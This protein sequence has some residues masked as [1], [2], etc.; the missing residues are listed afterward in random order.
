M[1]VAL[2]IIAADQVSKMYL[3]D[4]MAANPHGI[5][6]TSFFNLVMVWNHGVSFGMFAGGGTTRWIL[7]G[8]SGVISI[9]V[10]AMLK[11][12]T[13]KLLAVGLG[14]VLGGAIG[15]IF[16]RINYGAVA[17]FFDFD[18]IFMRWPAFNIADMA[19]VCGVGLMLLES[20][21]WGKK[22]D[23]IAS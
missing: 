2:L 19:I 17:D 21:F 23:K 18:L 8:V 5:E 4:L 1:I 9:V 6:V 7:V 15:N 10:V 3:I 16:D 13:N 22:S 20:L 11:K 12:A 14:L